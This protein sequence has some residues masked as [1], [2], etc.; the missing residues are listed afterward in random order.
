MKI[1]SLGLGLHL[2]IGWVLIVSHACATE[3]SLFNHVNGSVN[4]SGNSED[5][6][7]K[8]ESLSSPIVPVDSTASL[9]DPN[10]E[11]AEPMKRVNS[12]AE[13]SDVQPSDWAYQT[14]QS[15][16]KR[17][18]I[19]AGYADGTFRGD[20]ALTRYEF[21]AALRAAIPRI[22]LSTFATEKDR[23]D[24]QRMQMEFARELE[25]LKGKIS[26]LERIIQPVSETT[27]FTGEVVFAPIVV[28]A[29]EKADSNKP[30]DSELTISSRAKLNFLTKLGGKTL[31]RTTLKA[32]NIPAIQRASG[33][34]MA[35]LSFQGDSRNR[36]ELD[37][38]G[39]RS[40]LSKRV[41]LF[42]FM[43]GGSLNKFTE[44]LNPFLNSSGEGSI[45]RFGQRNPIYRQGGEVG[46][47]FSYQ[48]SPSI[49]LDMGYLADKVNNPK[50]GLGNAAY[51]AIAQLTFKFSKRAGLGIT[52]IRSFNSLDTNTGSDRANDPFDNSSNTI[53]ADSFGL[54]TTVGLSKK[55]ALSGWVGFS[56]TTAQDLPEKPSASLFNWAVT[57][58]F[59]NLG[60]EGN[61][62]GVVIGQPPK[63]IANDF[64]VNGK[65]FEDEDTSFHL[66]T[67][68]R[69]QLTKG[70]S[71]T[72]GLL[73]ITSPNHNRNNDSVFVGVIRTTFSF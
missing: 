19:I 30:T 16:I 7:N 40:Q 56:R 53:T 73:V 66:E 70:I 32:N 4:P 41:T 38:L 15:L 62:L 31:L 14:L 23:E 21:A 22:D 44:T 52:Y 11:V 67:F 39:L 63:V 10:E 37:E 60:R 47:G 2:L 54:E 24:L 34:D 29:T 50:V 59:P 49:S 35:R 17:Y 27:K 36:L 28:G 55:L 71:I 12:V 25:L 3:D 33:T 6:Y 69:I 13:L 64:R 48:F 57:I 9:F 42:G 8:Q 26:Q 68:Y 65:L 20:R 43:A 45:S 46:V 61:L 51:G 72:P 18:G 5:L 58:A 1:I